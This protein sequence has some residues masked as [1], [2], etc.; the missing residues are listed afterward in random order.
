MEGEG[1]ETY[2]VG[3]GWVGLSLGRLASGL[4]KQDASVVGAIVVTHVSK[5]LIENQLKGENFSIR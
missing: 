3:G 5:E 2:R 4:L 1:L